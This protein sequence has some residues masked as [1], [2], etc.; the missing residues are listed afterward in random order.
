MD[1]KRLLEGVRVVDFSTYIAAPLCGALLADL[2]AEVIKVESPS[3][4]A[5]R[6]FN[7]PERRG[8]VR[9]DSCNTG[10]KSV[11]INLQTAEGVAALKKLA[12][13]A[14]VFLTNTRMKSLAKRGL[15]HESLCKENPRLIY[16]W[17]SGYGEKGP[18]AN[19]PA[20]DSSAYW[21]KSG[22]LID[23]MTYTE[24]S[25][26]TFNPIAGGDRVTALGMFS[27]IMAALL[28]REQTGK[29][30]YVT[31]SLFHMGLFQN[32]L[33]IVSQQYGFPFPF[34]R[35]EASPEC[36]AFKCADGR[37]ILIA[38]MDYPR[39]GR[40]LWN[41][42]DNDEMFDKP[43][44]V[45]P[46]GWNSHRPEITKI[47][48]SI[49]IK[50]TSAEWIA[51]FAKRDIACCILE[52]AKSVQ[53]SEQAWAND[54]FEKYT[55]ETGK[56]YIIPR[57]IINMQS[58]PLPYI[59]DVPFEIGENTTEILSALGFSPEEIERASK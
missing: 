40:A 33:D 5:C 25:Y 57:S 17:I 48:D 31:T 35:G 49:M 18:D 10:K 19:L 34:P 44:Y 50:R 56:E 58:Q 22:L 11:C 3:G 42:F 7:H 59:H 27:L 12:A 55:A 51:E 24:T 26:P 14:D 15:D 8:N 45:F 6:W 16:A 4:D 13:S 2:G 54:Y 36:S 39:Q 38:I 37:W 52:D 47:I 30:D 23:T 53:S 21:A 41:A 1:E 46:D 28:R 20:Y 29:G 43:E 9:F 32:A